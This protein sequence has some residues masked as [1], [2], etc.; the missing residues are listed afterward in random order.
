MIIGPTSVMNWYQA[1]FSVSVDLID[2]FV[3]L[4]EKQ[5]EDSIDKYKTGKRVELVE[6]ALEEGEGAYGNIVETYG[7]LD[8]MSWSFEA[9]FEQYFPSLQRRAALITVYS[10]FEHEL[11]KLCI[12]FQHEKGLGL[13]PTDLRGKGF[14][15][16]ADYLQKVVGLPIDKQSS[17][18]K[19]LK[20]IRAIRNVIVHR[21][22][23]LQGSQG[24]IPAE[25]RDA[26]AHLKYLKAE[27]GQIVLEKAFVSQVVGIFKSYFK[28]LGD[29]I[30]LAK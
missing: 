21:D 1:D 26:M 13:T 7:G 24:K 19:S 6:E 5:A 4:M 17:E 29:S 27:D 2:S 22:G 3:S 14:E 20:K 15:Q 25:V 8:S 23:R 30:Q 12:L 10:Y 9:V 11:H 18:W 28:L 16:S